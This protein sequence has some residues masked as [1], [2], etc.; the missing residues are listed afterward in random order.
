VGPSDLHWIAG[1]RKQWVS[2]R[3][4][5]SCHFS[6]GSYIRP[7]IASTALSLLCLSN[8]GL[9]PEVF[10]LQIP[11][12]R[13]LLLPI[14]SVFWCSCQLNHV[15]LYSYQVKEDELDRECST[16]GEKRNS[17][18]NLVGTPKGKRPLGRPRLRW[19]NII[20]MDVR[21]IGWGGMDWIDLAQDRDRSRALVNTV[22]NLR[23]P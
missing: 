13:P 7:L 11:S 12:N 6:H 21:E 8:S 17:Y 14:F 23:V 20:R 4:I 19:E 16:N 5:F 15:N 18:K 22:I 2:I 1:R 10:S 3:R 9:Y